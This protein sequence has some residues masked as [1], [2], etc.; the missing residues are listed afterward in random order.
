MLR[1]RKPL[2]HIGECQVAQQT[3]EKH[4]RTWYEYATKKAAKLKGGCPQTYA[5]YNS[6]ATHYACVLGGIKSSKE[7]KQ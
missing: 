1:A 2:I 7:K 6:L 3:V 4:A 5:Y